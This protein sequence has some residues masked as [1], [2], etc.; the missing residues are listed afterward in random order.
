MERLSTETTDAAPLGPTGDV[1]IDQA[2]QPLTDIGD[3]PLNEH[4]HIFDT[5][6]HALQDHLS[7]SED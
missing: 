6:H 4:V 2:L 3:I 7:R 1:Q 5:L